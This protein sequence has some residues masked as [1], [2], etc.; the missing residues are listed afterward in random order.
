MI[1]NGWR[2][3]ASLFLVGTALISI[4]P[5]GTVAAQQEAVPPA[6]YGPVSINMEDVPYPYTVK[7][8]PLELNGQDVRLAY[9]DELPANGGNGTTVV[10]L[11]GLNFFGEY[12]GGTMQEL[13]DEGF[14]VIAIDQIGFG[15]SSKPIMPYTLG[16]MALN[17]RALLENL[18]IGRAAIVGHSMGGMVATRFAFY[19]PEVASHLVL[20]NPIG[21]TD[22]KLQRAPQRLDQSYESNLARSYQA[23]R[24]NIERYYSTWDPAAEKYV[25]IHYGW[26]QSADWPRLA[27]IRALLSQLI[28][29]EPVVYDWPRIRVRTLLI[30]GADDGQNFPEQA[31]QLVRSIPDADLHLIPNVGHN[32]HLEA[33]DRFRPVL[34]DFLTST[35]NP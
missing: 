35:G 15:R 1:A 32:P 27:R 17:I 4:P 25:R 20:V 6:D 13:L 22:A 5:I 28:Y 19:Y 30:G 24:N 10:F 31:S 2:R 7:Y 8:L 34:I 26:T 21:M 29:S 16:D 3:A 9:M 18:D 33:P 23:I 14:R 12:W 11:H